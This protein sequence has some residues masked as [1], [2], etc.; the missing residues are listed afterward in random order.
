MDAP[1]K[2]YRHKAHDYIVEVLGVQE[3]SGKATT[4]KVILV[5]GSLASKTTRAT[6]HLE[7]FHELFKP[8]GKRLRER[9]RW[10]R[11]INDPEL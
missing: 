10:D 2:R 4:F 8:V 5:R 9:T 7:K 3:C 6:W 11:L 1:Y